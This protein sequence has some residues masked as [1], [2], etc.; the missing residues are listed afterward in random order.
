MPHRNGSHD[1]GLSLFRRVAAPVHVVSQRKL[2]YL[3]QPV[4]AL[5][6]VRLVHDPRIRHIERKLIS[7]FEIEHRAVV[8]LAEVDVH[9]CLL[10]W[11]DANVFGLDES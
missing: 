8:L 11:A 2:D 1:D 3:A 10:S 9:N 7:A 6:G 5:G 4:V